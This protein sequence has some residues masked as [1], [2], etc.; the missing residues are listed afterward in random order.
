MSTLRRRARRAPQSVR[1]VALFLALLLPALAMYPSLLAFTTAAK[2]R[3]IATQYAPA[4][5]AVSAQDLQ[6]ALYAT[7]DEIDSHADSAPSSWTARRTTAAPTTDRAF[8]VWSETE[9]R[10]YRLTSAVELYGANG[11][12][13]SRF[14]LNLPGIHDRRSRAGR[15]RLGSARRSAAVRIEPTPRPPGQPRHLRAGT[16]RVGAIVVSVMLDYRTLPFIEAQSPYLESLQPDRQSLGEGAFGRDVEFVVYGWS[17]APIYASGTS[18]WPLP[19]AGVSADGRVAGAVLGH[20]RARPVDFRV[21]FM[22][23]RGGIYALGYPVI[24]PFGHLINV[25]EL[26]FLAGVLYVALS[27]GPRS[28]T[29]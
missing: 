17:R 10:T 13:V 19:D 3:L 18:V 4:G 22:S 25:A 20:H 8:M 24:T 26:I 15:L 11:R 5:G 16:Q 2:E 6:D 23:D 21:F 1:L 9:L 14:A 7:L 28:S 12:L 27:S 29:R